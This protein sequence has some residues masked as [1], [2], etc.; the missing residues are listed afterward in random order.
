VTRGHG[1]Y[2]WLRAW[3]QPAGL[4]G[5]IMIAGCWIGVNLLISFEQEN[6]FEAASQQS[7]HLARLFEEKTVQTLLGID[8]TLLLLRKG[9][10]DDADHFDLRNWA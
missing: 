6:T 5:L 7:E 1:G 3:F 4:L 8:R 10:E 9:L 2:T